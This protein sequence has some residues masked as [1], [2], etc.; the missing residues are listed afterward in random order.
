MKDTWW[1][2]SAR[3]KKVFFQSKAFNLPKQKASFLMYAGHVVFP[4]MRLLKKI[5]LR[6][7][8]IRMVFVINRYIAASSSPDA[9]L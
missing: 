7:I 5:I 2:Q 8:L 9:Y 3:I 1:F 4:D 6:A